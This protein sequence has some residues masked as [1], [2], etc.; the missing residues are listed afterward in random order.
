M[1]VAL[2]AQQIPGQQDQPVKE[3]FSDAEIEQF[4][5]INMDMMPIQQ[6]AE[7]KMIDAIES[8]GLEIERFQQLFQAQQ[9]GNITDA[10]EDPQEIAKFNEAGQQIMKVQEEA[11]QEIQQMILDADMQV[12]TFQE[13][14]TAYQQ[15][16]VVKA[17]VD[18]ILEKME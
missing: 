9:L 5:A 1:P 3:D 18:Q 13:I 11:N 4:V 6:A 7:A 2:S 16:P 15:S 12:Q 10:S 14:S 8:A 17:K